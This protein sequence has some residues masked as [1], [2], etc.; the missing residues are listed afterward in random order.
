MTEDYVV[1]LQQKS[2]AKSYL[3]QGGIDKNSIQLEYK[4]TSEVFTLVENT[5]A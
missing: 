3:F 4:Y 1:Q 5:E 2:L